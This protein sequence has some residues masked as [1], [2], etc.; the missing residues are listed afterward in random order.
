MPEPE[1][2]LLRQLQLSFLSLS[3]LIYS[4]KQQFNRKW[5][6]NHKFEYSKW[7]II[8]GRKI[9]TCCGNFPVSCPHL[10]VLCIPTWTLDIEQIPSQKQSIHTSYLTNKVKTFASWQFQISKSIA[11]CMYFLKFDRMSNQEFTVA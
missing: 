5:S 8:C 6:S 4:V 1:C 3:V 11:C 9:R 2:R 10:H 7:Y